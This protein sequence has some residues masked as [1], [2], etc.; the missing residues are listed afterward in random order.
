MHIL[1]YLNYNNMLLYTLHRNLVE[2]NVSLVADQERQP[3][4]LRIG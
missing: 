3:L 2:M 4:Q 1:G